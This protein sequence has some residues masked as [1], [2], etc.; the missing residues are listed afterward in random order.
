MGGKEM[1]NS[2]KRLWK[3]QSGQFALWIGLLGIPLSVCIGAAIDIE[4]GNR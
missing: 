2:I 3:D 1:K 4:N